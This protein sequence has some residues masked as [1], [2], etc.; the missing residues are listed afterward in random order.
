[1]SKKSCNRTNEFAR[2][3]RPVALLLLLC[4]P[5]F[6][7]Q[8]DDEFNAAQA[9]ASASKIEEAARLFCSVAKADPA[10]RNGEAAQNCKIYQDQVNRENARNEERYNDGVWG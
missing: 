8:K 9:A 6:A 10:Y 1:M 3:A 7:S 4:L 2:L 5:A